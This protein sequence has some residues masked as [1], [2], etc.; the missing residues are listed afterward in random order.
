MNVVFDERQQRQNDRKL[1]FRPKYTRETLFTSC[2]LMSESS[3][4]EINYRKIRP[5]D[6]PDL[7][8]K[9]EQSEEDIANNYNPFSLSEIHSFNPIYPDFFLLNE[10]NYNRI[11]LNHRYYLDGS[12]IK[13]DFGAEVRQETDVIRESDGQ[14]QDADEN[15]VTTE[16]K[17]TYHVKCSPILDPIHYLVGKY[18]P[19]KNLLLLPSLTN[20]HVHPKIANKQNASYIDG[21]FSYL[22]SQLKHKHN[23]LNAVDFYGSYLAIQKVFKATITDDLDYLNQSNYFM[24]NIG[25]GV[26]IHCGTNTTFDDFTGIGSRTNKKPLVFQEELDATDI[27]V[28][29][30]TL[31]N[32]DDQFEIREASLGYEPDTVSCEYIQTKTGGDS[33]ES[34]SDESTKE[35]AQTSSHSDSDIESLGS[36]SESSGSDSESS[37]DQEAYAYIDNF[38]ANLIFLEKCDGTLDSLFLHNEV[39]DNTGAAYLM[40]IIMSLIAFQKA[41]H[42]THNDLHTN[43][44]MYI[45]T[46]IEFLYY[47]YNNQFYQVPT[48]GKIFKIIDFGRAIYRFKDK[49]YCSDSFALKGDAYSQYN[50]EPY[51]NEKKPR[52]E[53]NLSFDLCRL[54]T[55][56]YDFIIQD[57]QDPRDAF[58]ETIYRW[59][60]D[61]NGKNV[62]YRSDGEERYPGFKLYKM[63]A[64]NVHSCLPHEQLKY[65]IF[66]DFLIGPLDAAKLDEREVRKYGLNIDLVEREYI[67]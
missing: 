53:A 5:L 10:S 56:I 49:I 59:C 52:V 12:S 32:T 30:L 64:R 29:E 38:P 45:N 33:D 41:F 39:D 42:F 15:Y 35:T 22:S 9:Y 36:E 34:D 51:F 18:Q 62:M 37:L 17:K 31:S 8:E 13:S 58:Q 26:S 23:M 28:V 46:E 44:I 67:N 20:E 57:E 7:A 19:A 16:S 25:K 14:G 54:G 1:F 66:M 43:N 2:I 60:L 48:Y 55:S 21:F 47:K 65:S 4:I 61:D 6:L 11:G 40:Q 50:T 3:H 63:I 24:E 27:G